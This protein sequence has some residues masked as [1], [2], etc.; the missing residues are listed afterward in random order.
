MDTRQHQPGAEARALYHRLQQQLA[1]AD[2]AA[3]VWLQRAPA[4]WQSLLGG[5]YAPLCR[6]LA[7]GQ[8]ARAQQLLARL[9]AS[10]GDAS[11]QQ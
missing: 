4:Q 8:Y 2:P 3:L 6:A 7:A 10:A 5:Q 1:A 11:A 9:P